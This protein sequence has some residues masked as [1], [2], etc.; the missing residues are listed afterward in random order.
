M[1][2]ITYIITTILLLAIGILYLQLLDYKNITSVLL[3]ENTSLINK[4][5]NLN[6]KV[7][8]LEESL[9]IKKIDLYKLNFIN[10]MNNTNILPQYLNPFNRIKQEEEFILIPNIKIDEENKITGFELEYKQKF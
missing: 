6:D 2:R 9:A 4:T 7:I 5:Y 8:L 3:K 10:D 1:Q